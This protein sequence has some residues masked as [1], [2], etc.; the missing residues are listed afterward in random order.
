MGNPK[1][2]WS[3]RRGTL[4]VSIVCSGAKGEPAAQKC[5]GASITIKWDGYDLSGKLTKPVD[6]GS[7]EWETSGS[8]IKLSAKKLAEGPHWPALFLGEKRSYVAKD[9]DEWMEEDEEL[10]EIEEKAAKAK[11]K[12]AGKGSTAGPSVMAKTEKLPF[13]VNLAGGWRPLGSDWAK[14]VAQFKQLTDDLTNR[15]IALSFSSVGAD[16]K[17]TKELSQALVAEGCEVKS[18]NKWPAAAWVEGCVW[19]AESADFVVIVHSDNYDTG[20]MTNAERW[21]IKE[22]NCPF[23]QLEISERAA[24]HPYYAADA[25]GAVKLL[26]ESL[27]ID[28]KGR[29]STNT[30]PCLLTF[31]ALDKGEKA[32]YAKLTNVWTPPA[33]AG[34][35]VHMTQEVGKDE[36][37]DTHVENQRKIAE[38]RKAAEAA[39]EAEAAKAKAQKSEA[40]EVAELQSM[41]AA[42][43]VSPRRSNL[44]VEMS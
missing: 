10:A 16:A 15:K 17:F 8:T 32:A 40:D 35:D 29:V 31:N 30:M 6:V 13:Y 19:A 33:D 14:I 20:K 1:V 28:Q 44:P 38:A 4:A 37:W 21:L 34:T 12:A 25:E 24:S 23:L 27:V 11:A 22:A 42:G 43:A 2:K 5:T 41:L 36:T 18:L 3:Q 7:V 9:M 26:K 39:A